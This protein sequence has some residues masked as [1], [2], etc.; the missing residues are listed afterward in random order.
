MV[1]QWIVKEI[2]SK[3]FAAELEDKL[4]SLDEEQMLRVQNVLAWATKVI[5]AN[6]TNG[7]VDLNRAQIAAQHP[8]LKLNPY[9]VRYLLEPAVETA[10]DALAKFR[11][12]VSMVSHCN[13]KREAVVRQAELMI[14]KLKGELEQGVINE[15]SLNQ[16]VKAVDAWGKKKQEDFDKQLGDIETVATDRIIEASRM[17]LGAWHNLDSN[18]GPVSTSSLCIGDQGML[19]I[20]EE[21]PTDQPVDQDPDLM[22][23]AELED[24]V[25]AEIA[26]LED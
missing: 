1:Q 25:S 4:D 11:D 15:S 24:A 9:E 16:R 6:C 5:G 3:F 23:L 21:M 18:M 2:A 20:P 12:F 17:I 13:D 10:N 19:S 8:Q 7:V 26:T 14:H 22:M